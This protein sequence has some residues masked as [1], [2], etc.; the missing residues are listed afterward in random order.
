MVMT[1]FR[2]IFSDSS[3]LNKNRVYIEYRVKWKNENTHKKKKWKKIYMDISLLLSVN[4][5]N[6]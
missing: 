1:E 4:K 6:G 2:P 3:Q 5:G